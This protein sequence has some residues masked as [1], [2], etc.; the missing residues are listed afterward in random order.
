MNIAV[1]KINIKEFKWPI[2]TRLSGQIF[3]NPTICHLQ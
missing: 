1:I 2:G 3:K